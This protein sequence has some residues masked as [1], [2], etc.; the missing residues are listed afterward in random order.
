MK[1][2]ESLKSLIVLR[3]SI[4]SGTNDGDDTSKKLSPTMNIN[5]MVSPYPKHQILSAKL[6]GEFTLQSHTNSDK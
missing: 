1:G 2:L 5:S 3:S 6:S 4:Y